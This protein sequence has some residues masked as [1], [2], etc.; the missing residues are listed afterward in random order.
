M[1]NIPRRCGR[2]LA[3]MARQPLWHRVCFWIPLGGIAFYICIFA[4]NVIWQD[5][6]VLVGLFN[7]PLSLKMLFAQHN[8]HRPLVLKLL[9]YAVGHATA[10]NS[11]ALM[12][13]SLAFL[14]AAYTA[15]IAS[16]KDALREDLHPLYILCVGLLVFSPVQYEN[17]LWGWQLGFITAYVFSIMALYCLSRAVSRHDGV[18]M[19]FFITA[20]GCAVT[21]SFCHSQG[22]LAW[23]AVSLM[24]TAYKQQ[25]AVKDKLFW[26]WN[27][28]ALATFGIYF[29][30]WVAPPDRHP[31]Y[32]FEHPLRFAH[33]ALT[34]LGGCLLPDT[35]VAWIA[36]IVICGVCVMIGLD[37]LR[38]RERDSVFPLGLIAYGFMVAATIS[39]GRASFGIYSALSSRY[40]TFM[41][42]IVVGIV[43]YAI[44][45]LPQANISIS[46]KI[47]YAI[48]LCIIAVSIP[49][50]ISYGIHNGIELK[51]IRL[52][53]KF[54]LQTYTTQPPTVLESSQPY[55]GYA[56][57][58]S[59]AKFLQGKNANIFSDNIN[60]YTNISD[61]RNIYKIHTES[62]NILTGFDANSAKIIY[63]AQGNYIQFSSWIIDAQAKDTIKEL[64]IVLNDGGGGKVYRAFYGLRRRDIAKLHKQPRYAYSGYT[65]DI[66]IN[67]INPGACR[68][69]LLA[70]TKDG[71]CYAVD[72]QFTLLVDKT[73]DGKQ[74]RLEKAGQHN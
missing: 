68:V 59:Y 65:R 30:G 2:I 16:M 27:A 4:V 31:L 28:A 10:L 6:F 64:Y 58:N 42:C 61:L 51:Q 69:T 66:P 23:L 62:D 37:F 52:M 9:A 53:D 14:A 60:I 74:I 8:E 17:L 34:L 21:A 46:Y 12:F 32:I 35:R 71:V 70:I 48:V 47:T 1:L 24:W 15:I 26:I 40:T 20:L 45:A 36:G 63:D 54:L 41:L 43:I 49:K 44:R 7:A 55:Y 3:A 33:Y 5:E 39:L 50:Q 67:L 13:V 19:P 56:A 29:A 22:L 57:I 73:Q 18:D 38:S 25:S 11:V 72:T